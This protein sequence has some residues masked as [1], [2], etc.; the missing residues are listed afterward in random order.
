MT[1]EQQAKK[2]E[3]DLAHQDRGRA[4]RGH[5]QGR[6]R[7]H[8]RPG[9]SHQQAGRCRYVQLKWIDKWDKAAHHA[10]GRQHDGADATAQVRTPAHEL[11]AARRAALL[12]GQTLWSMK[13]AQAA[14]RRGRERK[15]A[16]VWRATAR[17]ALAG[18]AGRGRCNGGCRSSPAAASAWRCDALPTDPDAV[19]ELNEIGPLSPSSGP[20]SATAWTVPAPWDPAPAA[21]K[22]SPTSTCR[23]KAATWCSAWRC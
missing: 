17:R 19:P 12:V 23:C 6:G 7:S 8:P 9:G 14:H 10:A 5:R 18:R 16:Q 3:H 15:P 21:R 11:A 1:A 22:P 4:A 2:A 13:R 20:A